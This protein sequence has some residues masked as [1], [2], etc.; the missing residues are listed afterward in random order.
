MRPLLAALFPF[1]GWPGE[2]GARLTEKT[3]I[4]RAFECRLSSD[5]KERVLA[6]EETHDL[7]I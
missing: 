5:H 1:L 7:H 3:F 6:H 4:R 2:L